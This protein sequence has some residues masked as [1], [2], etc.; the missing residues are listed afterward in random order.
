MDYTTLAQ[1]R[2]MV[3]EV[4]KRDDKSTEIDRAINDAYR[5]MIACVHPRKLK[6][7]IYHTCVLNREEYPL[8]EDVLRINHPLRLIDPTDDTNNSTAHTPLEF[9][10]KTD[11]D[12]REPNPNAGTIVP[13]RPDAYCIFKNSILLTPLPD[14][15]YL[16]EVNVGGVGTA[17]AAAADETI[18]QPTWDETHKAGA[19]ARLYIGIGLKEDADVWQSIYRWGFAGKEGGITGGLEL[20]KQLC[21]AY[22]DPTLIV[23]NNNL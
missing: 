2:T 3:L 9:I 16:I 4:F 12:E 8:P 15:A 13:G 18:F 1:F 7:Q 23:E 21:R 20:L 22:E 6:D 11:Y 14:K 19:L 17:L 10:N 5:E